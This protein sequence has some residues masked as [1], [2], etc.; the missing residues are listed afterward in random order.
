M[1]DTVLPQLCSVSVF[2]SAHEMRFLLTILREAGNLETAAVFVKSFGTKSA[3]LL[4]KGALAQVEHLVVH[5]KNL[6]AIVPADVAWRC[7]SLKASVVLG[8]RFKALSSF[9]EN[10]PALCIRY[11]FLGFKVCC[12]LVLL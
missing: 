7:L 10:I 12:P 9:A 11:R 1:W 8:L 4:L 6:H 3:P 5:I 2:D